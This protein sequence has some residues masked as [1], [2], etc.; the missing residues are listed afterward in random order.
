MIGAIFPKKYANAITGHEQ[1]KNILSHATSGGNKLK[2][3]EYINFCRIQYCV[4]CVT[5]IKETR[6]KKSSCNYVKLL[7][8]FS[9]FPESD[10]STDN[11]SD[12]SSEDDEDEESYEILMYF[13]AVCTR[14][15][16]FACSIVALHIVDLQ[17][18]V[19]PYSY[20]LPFHI[21]SFLFL[22]LLVLS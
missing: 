13:R 14:Y 11:A 7:V 19:A 1:N 20:K 17:E 9:L 6:S 18:L 2:Q 16:F 8:G 3:T 15:C 21:V 4:H 22:F 10:E 5:T 12:E